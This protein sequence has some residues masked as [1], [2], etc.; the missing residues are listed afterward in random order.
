MNDQDVATIRQIDT[1]P[2]GQGFRF[3]GRPVVFMFDAADT[4]TEVRHVTGDIPDGVIA[5]STA[6]AI[7]RVPGV[8]WTKQLAYLRSSLAHNEVILQFLVLKE[9]PINVNP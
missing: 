9:E 6:G 1:L 3:V 5:L 7:T 2:L 4:D 8:A